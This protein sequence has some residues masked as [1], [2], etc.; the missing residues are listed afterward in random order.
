M[1]NS[2]GAASGAITASPWGPGVPGTGLAVPPPSPAVSVLSSGSLT[3]GINAANLGTSVLSPS[4]ANAAFNPGFAAPDVMTAAP[5]SQVFAGA[6]AASVSTPTYDLGTPNPAVI[7]S[8]G[9]NT[10]PLLRTPAAP[11]G[12]FGSGSNDPGARGTT[13]TGGAGGGDSSGIP[14]S[15]FYPSDRNPVVPDLA[16][17]RPGPSD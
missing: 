14:S 11:T 10:T 8:S 9:Q 3:G 15:D 16:L 6:P 1:P 12:L 7:A 17:T 4:I 5:V 2:A 13:A